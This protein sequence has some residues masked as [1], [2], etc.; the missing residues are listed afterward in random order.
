M[1]QIWTMFAGF[2]TIILFYVYYKTHRVKDLRALQTEGL[3]H[4]R[5]FRVL[6]Y[7]LQKHRGLSST[8]IS[9][10]HTLKSSISSVQLEANKTIEDIVQTNN[11]ILTNELWLSVY[12]HWQRLSQNYAKN[13]IENNVLQHNSMIQNLLYLVDDIAV[14]HQLTRLKLKNVDNIRLIWKEWLSAI[15]CIGQ[16]RAMGSAI[17]TDGTCSS[18]SRIRLSYLQQKITETTALAWRGI[19]VTEEQK[20]Q[21][22]RLIACIKIQIIN[23]SQTNTISLKSTDYFELCSKVIDIYYQRFDELVEQL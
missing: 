6:L 15:E 19:P 23:A 9:G 8:Y 11:S 18:V 14:S 5:N 3:S 13:T 2:L 17:L 7:L 20:G 1:Y 10:Q 21:V 4:I 12:E 22:N 16:A